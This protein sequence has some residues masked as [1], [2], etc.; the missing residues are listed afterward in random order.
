[1]PIHATAIIDP[2]AQLH[3]TVDVGPYVVID[4]PVRIGARTRIL[5]HAHICGDTTIGEDNVIHMSAVIGHVPQITGYDGKLRRTIIGNRN[6]LREYV[7]IHCASKDDT[8]TIVGDDCMFMVNSHVGHD[9]IIGN[10]VILVN[11]ALVGGHAEI[12]EGAFISGNST[13]HQRVRIGRFAMLQ[14]LTGVSKDVCPFMRATGR[15]EIR[16]INMVR[17]RREGFTPEA[18]R[19]IK[20]A[21]RIL[22][23]RRT[24]IPRAVEQLKACNFGAEVQEIIRF[25]ESSKLGVLTSSHSAKGEDE[26]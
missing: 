22:F 1:M 4:G 11:G 13:I 15:N 25:I 10:K 7:T 8:A 26:D 12:Q 23:G 21:Y 5:S 14:G 24:N 6:D 17:L 19:E 3:E 9:C 2:Q 20:E 18:R 16:T